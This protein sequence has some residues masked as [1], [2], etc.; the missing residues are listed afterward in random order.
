MGVK[1]KDLL[2]D[3]VHEIS[4]KDL[5]YKT[6]AFDAYN[7]LHQ[8]LASVRQYDGTPLM[9]SRGNLTGHL[10]GLFYRTISFLEEGIKPVFVF[11]GKSPKWKEKT[12]LER[13][14]KRKEAEEEYLHALEIEDTELLK[15]LAPQKERLTSVMINESKKLLDLM[16]IPYVDAPSEG[17]AFAAILSKKNLV[18]AVSSQDYDSLLFGATRL[19]RNLSITGKRRIQGREVEI[20]PE[21]FT[22]SEINEKLNLSREKL[23]WIGIL[24]G[25]DFNKGIAGIGPKKAF[26]MVMKYDTFQEL[27]EKENLK[28]V[29]GYETILEIIDFYLNPEEIDFDENNLKLR[30]LDVEGIVDFLCNQRDFSEERVRKALE[31]VQKIPKGQK[32]LDDFF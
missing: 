31:K 5:A 21:M 23:I 24:I 32:T 1:L 26:K 3:C 11:D 30:K 27:V 15:K 20:N 7:I 18:Y 2:K 19:I 28:F 14:Q 17:E 22:L 6:I 8:F 13:M 12:Q 9:D 4:I 10:S 16:G 25:T 29:E